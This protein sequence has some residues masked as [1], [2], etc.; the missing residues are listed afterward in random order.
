M[1]R[2]PRL[3]T[4]WYLYDI[5]D[6]FILVSFQGYH[7]FPLPRVCHCHSPK[8]NGIFFLAPKRSWSLPFPS[9][10]GS[11]HDLSGW[12]PKWNGEMVS[13]WLKFLWKMERS[14]MSNVLIL[15]CGVVQP[16]HSSFFSG[17]CF[18]WDPRRSKKRSKILVLSLRDDL[19]HTA[20]FTKFMSSFTCWWLNQPIRKILVKKLNASPR[21]G[22]KIKNIWNHPLVYWCPFFQCPF[23][24]TSVTTRKPS[25]FLSAQAR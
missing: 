11:D 8:R 20:F 6:I 12:S 23:Q 7:F 25:R 22:V 15:W 16:Q 14:R 2:C 9:N 19:W 3:M 24:S 10:G 17:K 5:F 4:V 18:A 1:F 13:P 21:I